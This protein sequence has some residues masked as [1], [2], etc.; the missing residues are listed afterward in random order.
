[1]PLKVTGVVP[2][3]NTV[4]APKLIVAPEEFDMAPRVAVKPLVLNVPL[5]T[6]SMLI[7]TA[8]ARDTT[9]VEPLSATPIFTVHE[10][11]KLLPFE[12]IENAPEV[13]SKLTVQVPG[14]VSVM[15]VEKVTPP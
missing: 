4:L 13:A 2:V 6:F 8:S 3:K 1:M 5:R 7:V 15:P 12:R 10:P 11:G 14:F 9:A